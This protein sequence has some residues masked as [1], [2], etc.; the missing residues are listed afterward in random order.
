[1]GAYQVTYNE[2]V[3]TEDLPRIPRNLQYRI[4]KAIET[5]LATAPARY[6]RRL[7]RSLLGLWRLRV[8]DYRVIYEIEASLVKVWMVAHRKEAYQAITRRLGSEG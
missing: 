3:S 5:R 8:G 2:L 6:G 1:M 7:S 4:R